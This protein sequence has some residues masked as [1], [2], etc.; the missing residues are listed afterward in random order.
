MK[1]QTSC[2]DDRHPV[3]IK[4]KMRDYVEFM[5]EMLKYQAAQRTRKVFGKEI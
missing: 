3:N 2:K 5:R 4:E 1:Y